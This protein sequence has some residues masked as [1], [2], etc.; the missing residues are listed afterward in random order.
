[1]FGHSCDKRIDV[2]LDHEG[3]VGLRDMKFAISICEL[4]LNACM[5]PSSIQY[6]SS[7]QHH[8]G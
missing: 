5:L 6:Q 4:L 2:F 8:D 7:F 3:N 1:M